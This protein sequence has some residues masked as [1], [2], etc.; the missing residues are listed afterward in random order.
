MLHC[1]FR[2]RTIMMV[3]NH[4][5]LTAIHIKQE[6]HIYKQLLSKEIAGQHYHILSCFLVCCL[7]H[8]C[9]HAWPDRP[10]E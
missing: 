1:D 6:Q 5:V 8:K 7:T 3:I 10:R 9:S 4:Y 2:A